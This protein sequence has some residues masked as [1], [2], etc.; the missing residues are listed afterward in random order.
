MGTPAQS[1]SPRSLAEH[2]KYKKLWSVLGKFMREIDYQ[3]AAVSDNNVI[4]LELPRGAGTVCLGRDG[5]LRRLGYS[6]YHPID[7]SMLERNHYVGS[8]LRMIIIHS[9]VKAIKMRKEKHQSS[10]AN[11][12]RVQ[13]ALLEG[14]L[15]SMV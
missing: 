1:K 5:I 8:Q 13:T 3:V 6:E 7:P 9:A 2:P 12:D 4:K 10:I 15:K 14:L 11:L